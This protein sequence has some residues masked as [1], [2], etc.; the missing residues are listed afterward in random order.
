MHFDL[1]GISQGPF[2][3]YSMSFHVDMKTAGLGSQSVKFHAMLCIVQ[4]S[5]AV[6]QQMLTLLG[7]VA[8]PTQ[9]V[10]YLLGHYKFSCFCE[11]G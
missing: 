8:M 1:Q 5:L 3:I 7:M 11:F 9:F 6:L 10:L 4:G 2:T